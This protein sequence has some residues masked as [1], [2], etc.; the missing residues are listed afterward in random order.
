MKKTTPENITFKLTKKCKIEN[1]ILKAARE[2]QDM[3][4]RKKNE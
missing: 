1:K 4:G 3:Y 2:R